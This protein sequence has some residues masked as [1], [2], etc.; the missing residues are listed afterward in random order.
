MFR[1]KHTIATTHFSWKHDPESLLRY[2]HAKP[3]RAPSAAADLLSSGPREK[4]QART[5]LVSGTGTRT[6]VY[7]LTRRVV[8]TEANAKNQGS[9]RMTEKPRELWCNWFHTNGLCCLSDMVW[10]L[11]KGLS[12]FRGIPVKVIS[13]PCW[14]YRDYCLLRYSGQHPVPTVQPISS[15]WGCRV[16]PCLND[17]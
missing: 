12:Q 3:I 15:L 8:G 4:E 10:D 2:L 13:H 7:F 11:E 5:G 9:H 16:N 6:R 1:N 17:K 14:V